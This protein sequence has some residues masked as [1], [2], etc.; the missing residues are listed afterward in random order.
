MNKTIFPKIQLSDINNFYLL[1]R[2]KLIKKIINPQILI[3]HTSLHSSL[4]ISLLFPA[5]QLLLTQGILVAKECTMII[6]SHRFE[7]GKN[8]AVEM[9]FSSPPA[10]EGQDTVRLDFCT[11]LFF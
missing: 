8:L 5:Y 4:I 6:K 7:I 11:T 2:Y 10:S 9:S 3:I 1:T